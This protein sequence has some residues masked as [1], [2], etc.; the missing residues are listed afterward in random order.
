MIR[1]IPL[2]QVESNYPLMVTMDDVD[3]ILYLLWNERD[4][5]WF[6]TIRDSAGSDIVSGVKVV[7]NIPLVVHET[8]GR[9]FPGQLWA[10]DTTGS[11]TDPGLRDFGT[12]VKL[13]YVDLASTA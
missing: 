10:I 2:S 11:E 7:V 1:L 3:F 13:I 9:I 6:M 8:D 4:G 5:H 12:R